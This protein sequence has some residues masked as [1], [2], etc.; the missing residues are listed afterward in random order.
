M[1][2]AWKIAGLAALLLVGGWLARDAASVLPCGLSRCT[3]FGVT[4]STDTT[5]AGNTIA[6][7]Y[8]GTGV[9]NTSKTI[10]LGGNLTTN[11]ALTINTSTSG[12][13]ATWTSATTIGDSG[14]N[15]SYAALGILAK[16]SSVN[17]NASGDTTVTLNLGNAT[18]YTLGA[19]GT[20]ATNVVARFANCSAAAST[21]SGALYTATS[22]GGNALTSVTTMSNLTNASGDMQNMLGT[23]VTTGKTLTTNPIYFNPTVL[24]GSAVTC[25]LYVYGSVVP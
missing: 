23:P 21:A 1:S 24:Q 5:Y 7:A 16:V 19:T 20:T 3:L 17:L 15:C 11:S 14:F 13:C 6:G 4:L 2:K 18:K 22:K 10:T 8:G 9:A 25:D 12:N